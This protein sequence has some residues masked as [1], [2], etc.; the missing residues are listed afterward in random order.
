MMRPLSAY[1]YIREN[2]GRAAVLI[3][4]LFLTTLFY[5]AGNYISSV[6]YYWEKI[7]E[8]DDSICLIGALSTDE[9]FRDYGE[10]LA[11]LED[12]DSLVVMRRSARGFAGLDWIC[13]MGFEMGS[14][15]FVFNTP[16]DMK[17]AFEMLGIEADLSDTADR[18]VVMSAA[19]AH[20]HGLEVGS[21]LDSSTDEVIWDSYRVSALTEDNCYALFYVHSDDNL[22]RANVM[23]D[24]LKGEELRRYLEDIRGDLKVNIT[25]CI[26]ESLDEEFESFYMIFIFAMLLLSVIHATTIN[27]V[28]S[29]QFLRRRY[30]FGIFRAMG[31][32]G[33][34]VF[35]KIASEICLADMIAVVSGAVF[36]LLLTFMLNELVYIPSG[37]YLPYFSAAGLAAFLISNLTVVIPTILIRSRSM[38][39]A[40][41][42]E[43]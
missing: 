27:V 37:K 28:L 17:R 5:L 3:M 18:C 33:K 32:S 20:Q 2:K 22:M 16:E 39:G 9:D 26:R 29:G 14:Y 36:N 23:S 42:T 4:L 6:D 15:G 25:G 40:D 13:T 41:V 24:T 35:L 10:F 7:E 8:Y 12:D 43:F 30:E 38:C 19:L 1:Y 31:M 34:S 11:R 21:V